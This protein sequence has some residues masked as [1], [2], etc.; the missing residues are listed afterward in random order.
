MLYAYI[1]YTEEE[2]FYRSHNFFSQL[3]RFFCKVLTSAGSSSCWLLW[4]SRWWFK[5]RLK[6]KFR[7]LNFW[8]MRFWHLTFNSTIWLIAIIYEAHSRAGEEIVI[9][10]QSDLIWHL[11]F[12]II[13]RFNT[14]QSGARVMIVKWSDIP[15]LFK[16]FVSIQGNYYY[17]YFFLIIVHVCCQSVLLEVDLSN[18]SKSCSMLCYVPSR[19]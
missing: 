11:N 10:A 17:K 8:F 9:L 18:H 16:L 1:Q 5:A 19:R 4:T 6:G 12:D 7:S 2:S 14:A 15:I 3:N 13:T